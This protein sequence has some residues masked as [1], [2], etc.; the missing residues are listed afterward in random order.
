MSDDEGMELF[1]GKW[2]VAGWPEKLAAAQTLTHYRFPGPMARIPH[3]RIRM[4][5]RS[6]LCDDCTA[7]PG[8]LHVPGCLTERCPKCGGQAALCEDII[9]S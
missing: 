9:R 3:R 5:P 2:V 6:N 1:R 4:W 7:R 8:E